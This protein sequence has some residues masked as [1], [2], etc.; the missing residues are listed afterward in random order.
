MPLLSDQQAEAVLSWCVPHKIII[1]SGAVGALM[2]A[3]CDVGTTYSDTIQDDKD[4]EAMGTDIC[5]W[6]Q[7][8]EEEGAQKFIAFSRAVAAKY[9]KQPA[10]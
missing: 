9:R 3:L 1:N 8:I 5:R 2:Q 10:P 7:S 4:L 6:M